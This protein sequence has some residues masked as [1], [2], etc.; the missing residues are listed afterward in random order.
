MH[1]NKKSHQTVSKHFKNNEDNAE[2]TTTPAPNNV[3]FVNDT[4]EHTFK[5][6]ETRTVQ[7]TTWIQMFTKS[8]DE[9][10]VQA[11][12][13]R[14][15]DVNRSPLR[16]AL[17]MPR[18]NSSVYLTSQDDLS[19]Y[20]VDDDIHNWKRRRIETNS[21]LHD[22]TLI[23][24]TNNHSTNGHNASN[25]NNSNSSNTS[26]ASSVNDELHHS[27]RARF[28]SANTTPASTA[29]ATMTTT[30]TLS[31]TASTSIRSQNTRSLNSSAADAS[32][33]AAA[34]RVCGQQRAAVE[35]HGRA[36]SERVLCDRP[37]AVD[38]SRVQVR[39]CVSL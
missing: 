13:A 2:I 22:S 5:H 36:P 26:A 20:N 37:V 21:E 9:S 12:P 23:S 24:N 39:A 30:T 29:M 19:N 25:N 31:S 3:I 6:F 17:R 32:T 18:T 28:A 27:S 1:A 16:G 38:H 33:A 14:G 34:K 35:A 15:V 8:V 11:S 10:S 7:T 4:N